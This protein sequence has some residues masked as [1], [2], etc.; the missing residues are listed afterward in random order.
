MTSPPPEPPLAEDVMQ[1]VGRRI[2]AGALLALGTTLI[3]G[4]TTELPFL[5]VV[6][7]PLFL[8]VFPTLAVAQTPVLPHV[9]LDRI[10]AY[11]SSG[12]TILV[13][14]G[15]AM[16]LVVLG[17][18]PE[19]AG[20]AALPVVNFALWTA[21]LTAGAL[22]LSLAFRPFE[23]RAWRRSPRGTLDEGMIDA[24]LPRTPEERRLF[25]GLSL[26]AGWGEEMAYRGYLPAGLVLA[27]LSPWSAMA[28]AS[29]AF[30]ALHAYQGPIGVVRTALVGILLGASVIATGS[31][32]PAMAAHALLDLVLGL[33]IGPRLLSRTDPS[34]PDP[35]NPS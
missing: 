10:P 6:A 22:G 31:L 7:V 15:V 1:Q 25:S 14:G 16:G 26:A 28:V 33:V 34:S 27:G 24:L 35:R 2:R 5:H 4:F 30:G 12:L 13:M 32:F 19:A 11:L 8:V 20:I 29:V 21:G 3:L 23:L 9:P 18:G 17:P